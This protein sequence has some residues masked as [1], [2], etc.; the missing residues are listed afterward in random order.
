M[1]QLIQGAPGVGKTSVLNEIEHRYIQNL[2]A[3]PDAHRVIPVIIG[4]SKR[5]SVEHVHRACGTAFRM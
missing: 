3:N 2:T 1:M 4:D 5:L